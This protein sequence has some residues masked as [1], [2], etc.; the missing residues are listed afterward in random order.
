MTCGYHVI[1]QVDGRDVPTNQLF[2]SCSAFVYATLVALEDEWPSSTFGDLADEEVVA[3][4]ASRTSSNSV[5]GEAKDGTGKI[6][7]SPAVCAFILYIWSLHNV[8]D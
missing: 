4:M 5:S 2:C 8:R 7:L 1:Q 6:Y 3:A